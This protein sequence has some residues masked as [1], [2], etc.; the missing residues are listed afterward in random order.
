[1]KKL[2]ICSA[3]VASLTFAMSYA[4]A[5]D[6]KKMVIGFSVGN[7]VEPFFK[8]MEDGI[9]QAAEDMGIEVIV[10]SSESD[11]A[12]Q[13]NNCEDF[14]TNN[15]NAIIL[16][17]IDSTG[18]VPAVRH[19]N[20]EGI[21]V[22][23]ADITVESGDIVSFVAADN[24]EGGR[25]AARFLAEKLDGKGELF[26]LD[27]LK[28][29]SVSQRSDAF[30]EELA[31][32]APGIKIVERTNVGFARDVCM[33]ATEDLILTYP[34]LSAIFA[35]QGGDAGLGA[36]AAVIAAGKA[37]DIV[38]VNFDCEDESI[39]LIK[40]GGPMQADVYQN[41]YE[42]GYKAVEQAF[43]AIKGENVTP[44]IKTEVKLITIANLDEL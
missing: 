7:T 2:L 16:T 30:V 21:P 5:A 27:D 39:S 6:G 29:T 14:I 26:I 24:T 36:A 28:I 38:I 10:A 35:A 3:L 19:A 15:V 9:R 20:R 40:K 25:L 34:R 23:T 12:R 41:P 18:V 11:V 8:V 17:P 13:V 37:K 44:D 22:I 4:A 33:K 43:K 42:I 32:I 31:K 1:M